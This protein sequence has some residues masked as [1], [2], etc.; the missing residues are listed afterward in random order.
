MKLFDWLAFLALVKYS[1]G[2]LDILKLKEYD[3]KI[4]Q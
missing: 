2:D 3:A 1:Y 4:F